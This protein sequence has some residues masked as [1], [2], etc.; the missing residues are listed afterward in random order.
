[1]TQLFI[2][3]AQSGTG[4]VITI[5]GLLLV[6]VIIGY[7]SAWF[8][9]KSIYTPIIKGLEADKATLNKQVDGLKDDI[10]RLNGKVEKLNEKITGLENDIAEKEKEIKKLAIPKKKV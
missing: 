1:M 9:A 5:I 8:Y 7:L 3:L 4:A 6:A 10:A 2:L